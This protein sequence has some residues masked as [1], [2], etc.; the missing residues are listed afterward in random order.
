MRFFS[1]F[2][3]EGESEL[4][5]SFASMNGRYT[6][7]GF[8]YGAILAFKEALN[9]VRKSH[10]IQSLNLFS[11]AFFQ[12][13]KPSFLKAQ[14]LGFK[15]DP[16][17]YIQNFLSLCGNPPAK[18][19]KQGTLEQLEELLSFEWRREELELLCASGVELNIFV[20]G[21]DKIISSQ[22]VIDFF[23]PFG[24]VHLYQNLNHHLQCDHP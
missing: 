5:A 3:F 7:N 15:K 13:R 1:G 8:S 12:E 4:F 17:S 24:I 2:C 20:G 22:E 10:R 19:F 14:I 18:Y 9:L 23:T 21:K 6:L 16:Q 11:P